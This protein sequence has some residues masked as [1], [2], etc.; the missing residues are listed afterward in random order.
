M[1]TILEESL[2]QTQ[3]KGFEIADVFL[4]PLLASQPQERPGFE[5]N[6]FYCSDFNRL[7]TRP[8]EK[9]FQMVEVDYFDG[10]K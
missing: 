10:E 9:V 4:F 3:F 8:L 5:A 1:A 7:G 2:A 6:V